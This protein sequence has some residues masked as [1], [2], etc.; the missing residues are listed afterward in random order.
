VHREGRDDGLVSVAPLMDRCG[1]R[2]ADLLDAGSALAI[3]ALRAAE[4]IG[5]P[6]GSAFFLDRLAA[7]TGC[8]PRPRRRGPKPRVE[9]NRG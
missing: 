4:T 3:S 9:R 2:F 8:N 6:L 7:A 5:R 1:G